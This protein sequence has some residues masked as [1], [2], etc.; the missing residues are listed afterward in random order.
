MIANNSLLTD[1]AASESDFTKLTDPS[2][3]E[4]EGETL[5]LRMESKL[6]GARKSRDNPVG[7]ELSVPQRYWSTGNARGEN[8]LGTQAH[9]PH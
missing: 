9:G 5:L 6:T 4:T 3:D 8:E 1:G 7:E 2:T